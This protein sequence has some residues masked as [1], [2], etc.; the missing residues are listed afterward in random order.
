MQR[1]A[2]MAGETPEFY[3]PRFFISKNQVDDMGNRIER[4]RKRPGKS[5]YVPKVPDS[6]V[7]T[8]EKTFDAADE[9][10]EKTTKKR[11]DDTGLVALVCRHDHPLFLCNVDTPGEQQKFAFALVE[12]LF[13]FLPSTATVVVLYDIGCVLDRSMGL[14]CSNISCY[15]PT[16]SQLKVSS[17][18]V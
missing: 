11:F 5:T 9:K 2:K 1:H 16:L 4:A 17:I 7:D 13:S 12:H 18:L 14:V 6:A 8:C 15:Q 10:F 3:N